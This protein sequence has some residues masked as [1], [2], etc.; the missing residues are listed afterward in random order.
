MPR[1]VQFKRRYE[2][3]AAHRA[4]YDDR[5]EA[6]VEIYRQMKGVYRKL[7]GKLEQRALDARLGDA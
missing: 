5:F 4:V 1:L 2:P 6:F 7:N 3:T